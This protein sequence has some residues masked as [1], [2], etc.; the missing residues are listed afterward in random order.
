MGVARHLGIRLREYDAR[1]R[2]FIPDYQAMLD[3][4]AAAM[5][6]VRS[7]AP[8]VLDLGIGTGALAARCLALRPAARIIGLDVDPG[9]F[10]TARRRLG[11]R[12]TTVAGDFESVLLPASDAATAA[13]ALHHVRTPQ[14]K[15]ALY[16]RIHAS[17]RAGGILSIADTALSS[18]PQL[19]AV[20]HTAWE[21]HLA[22]AYG[23]TGARRYLAAWA[24]EDRY[25]QLPDEIEWLERAGFMVEV[26]WRRHGF[27]V[28]HA[29]KRRRRR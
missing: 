21:A 8:V 7:R 14:R 4:A 24:R 22:R 25:F 28:L 9:M 10:G 12:L 20:D 6:L 3:A 1:I 23:T 19:R 13:F 2:T 29:S 15:L 26:R 18:T 27:V 17:L 5:H 16:R 11:A